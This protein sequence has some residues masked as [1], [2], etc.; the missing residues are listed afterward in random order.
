MSTNAQPLELPPA[1]M[2]ALRVA[3]ATPPRAYHHFGHVEEVLAHYTDVAN[4]VGWRSPREVMLAVLFHDAIYD[5]GTHD[6][7]QRSAAMAREAIV[8]HLGDTV[9]DADL[10]ERLIVLTAK[11]GRLDREGLDDDT[12]LFLDCDMAIL[13]SPPEAYD[14]YEQA[15]AQEYAA[16]PE[17][18]YRI[19]RG[20]F[21]TG[22]LARPRIYLSDRF[23]AS[24]DAAARE[25]LG[26]ALARLSG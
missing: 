5:A 3:Y 7:E 10:V 20:A 19:G 14:R 1:M 2:A 24:H 23:H 22:L 21:L 9:I 11:H 6:N 12:R 25:N 13:G 18:A 15:I 17:A 16:V 8:D 4:T 26:R